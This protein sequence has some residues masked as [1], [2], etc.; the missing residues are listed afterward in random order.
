ML[1]FLDTRP[2]LT[3]LA[4]IRNP[5]PKMPD[6]H[7]I[8]LVMDE[9]KQKQHDDPYEPRKHGGGADHGQAQGAAK[10]AH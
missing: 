9:Y 2:R 1:G 6:Y 3:Y 8:P 4:R 10:G 7:E 5:N